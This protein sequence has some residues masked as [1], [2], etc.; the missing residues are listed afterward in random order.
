MK[1]RN[2]LSILLVALTLTACG[3]DDSELWEQ[4]NQ[5]TERIAALEAWQA[6][7]NTNIQSIQT[8]LSTTDYITAVTPIVEAGVEVGYTISFLNSPAITVYHGQKGDMGEQG[9]DGTIPQI[10]VTQGEDG[11]WYWTLNGALLADSQGN[12][13]RADGKTGADGTSV[14]MPQLA[15]G[16]SLS[17]QGVTTDMQGAALVPDAI[18]LSVNGG[19]TWAR[20]SGEKGEQGLQGDNMFS[21]IDYE[22]EPNNVTFTLNDGT[23]FSIPRYMGNSLTF[24]TETL[25]LVYGTSK[26]IAV[27]AGGS[28]NFTLDNLY[29]VAPYGWKASIALTRTA[30]TAFTLTVTAPDYPADGATE[31]EILVVLDS[32][33]GNTTIGRLKVMA[34]LDNNMLKEENLQPGEL[35]AAIGNRTGLTSITVTSGSIN[36][37]DWA[38]IM[39][40]IITLL[41]LDL[42]GVTYTGTDG[43]SLIYNNTSYT[44]PLRIAK[45]PQGIT[46][47]GKGAFQRCY[48]LTYI[49]LP[50]GIISIGADAFLFCSSL[51][52]IT[53][54]DEV[55]SIGEAAFAYCE[56]LISVTIPNGVTSIGKNAFYNCYDLSSIIIPDGVT[57][58]SDYAF[59]NCDLTSITFPDGVT[60]I[61]DYAFY[62]NE[63]TSIN[64]PEDLTSIGLCAFGRSYYLTSITIPSKVTSIG[65]AVFSDCDVLSTVICQ[66]QTPPTLETDIFRNCAALTSIQVP[67][68]SVEAYKTAKYWIEHADIITAIP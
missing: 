45:L 7:T 14:P 61:G 28:E 1:T 30:G 57:S 54:P 13:I 66:A 9:E 20:V 65:N 41:Y 58:I 55:T 17:T 8:L 5:N 19:K 46:G 44:K 2:R 52:S 40:N 51:V 49:T 27:T 23:T 26:D 36:E 59:Y 22:S 6:E 15:T 68:A 67:A 34:T 18:Y 62:G 47:L 33:Q 11:N 60:S 21:D 42:E 50:D 24:E 43:N 4:V 25:P 16:T 12:S 35:A 53:F 37:T 3:Y 29:A 63:L 64:L 32:G 10:G 31:G 48:N 39:E 38:A 56:D